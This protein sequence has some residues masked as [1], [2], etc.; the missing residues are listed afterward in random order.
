MKISLGF[1]PC[2]ND[3][4][5]FDALLHGRIDT[6]GLS[7]EPVIADVEEL[8]RRAFAGDL[9]VTKLSFHAL[10]HLLDRYALLDS[11][12]ALGNN[13]GPL[14]IAR[15][16]LSPEAIEAGPIA[17]PGR[18]TTANF[19]LGLAFPQ[20]KNKRETLFSQ[21]EQ[22]VLD[23][24]VAAGL[25]I[26]ENRFTYQDKG[27]VKLLD[28]GEYWESQYQLPIPL[29]G[30]AVQRNLPKEV[31][32]KVNRALRA[33]VQYAFDHPDAA[34]PFIRRHAQEMDEEVMYQHIGLYVNDFTLELGELGR[35]A[36]DTLYRVAREHELIPPASPNDAN[37]SGIWASG[38]RGAS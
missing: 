16:P 22:A 25:I 20:A 19:L 32:L 14:L 37:G 13:C 26:H 12:S 8:N 31:Q 10:G 18:Y 2:P 28:C 36:I 5:I 3:T 7:F 24:T 9:H 4:F 6:E 1:S 34:L 33:S 15:Q 21:I 30:I 17:I 35:R 29:G 27:L 38:H 11:G 23:G